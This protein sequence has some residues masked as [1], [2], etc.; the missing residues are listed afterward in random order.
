MNA[1]SKKVRFVKL[2]YSIPRSASEGNEL[3]GSYGDNPFDWVE[4]A[5]DLAMA[6]SD[7]ASTQKGLEIVN[8]VFKR[9]RLSI[10]VS[11]TKTMIFNYA[12]PPEQYPTSIAKLDDE[13]VMNVKSFKY[14]GGII[15]FDQP[16]TS[17]TKITT[18]IDMAETKFYIRLP[19]VDPEQ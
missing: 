13:E 18:R 16:T 10:N 11:K 19:D 5:D 12:E 7:I 6:F 4:Y 2:K 1:S 15:Q 8:E 3:L 9:F 14:L 17:D